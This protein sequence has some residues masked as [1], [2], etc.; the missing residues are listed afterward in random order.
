MDRASLAA[1]GAGP[2]RGIARGDATPDGRTCCHG[3]DP[4]D[5]LPAEAPVQRKEAD[6]SAGRAEPAAD[7]RQR[8]RQDPADR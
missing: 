8:L 6:H 4:C 2:A 1:G 3:S 5:L 7:L